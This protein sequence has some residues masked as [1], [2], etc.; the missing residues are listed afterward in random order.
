MYSFFP[1]ETF[2]TLTECGARSAPLVRTGRTLCLPPRGPFV[3]KGIF[4]AQ[5]SPSAFE[6]PVS[7]TVYRVPCVFRG[8]SLVGAF[9]SSLRCLPFVSVS[10]SRL[11]SANA[12][13]ARVVRTHFRSGL[14]PCAGRAVY[15]VSTSTTLLFRLRIFLRP[16]AFFAS[17]SAFSLP[18]MPT[19][20]ATRV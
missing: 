1:L 19:W 17:M 11:H 18:G 13:L 2:G 6:P 4:V 9:T 20:A 10:H 8:C 3:R 7:L 16:V 15:L 12:N 5:S 14:V